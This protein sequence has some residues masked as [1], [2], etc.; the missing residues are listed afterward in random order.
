MQGNVMKS[1]ISLCFVAI[2]ASNLDSD[3]RVATQL[4]AHF[5]AGNVSSITRSDM[6]INAF[7]F[8]AQA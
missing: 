3:N 8:E 7:G 6:Q 4:G 1:G 2:S 5:V